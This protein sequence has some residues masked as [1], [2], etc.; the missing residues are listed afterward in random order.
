MGKAAKQTILVVDDEKT[1]RR[2]AVDELKA[3]GYEVLAAGSGAEALALLHGHEG[4]I[5]LLLTDVSMPG[6]SGGELA[7]V[8]GA[9][10][11]GMKILYMSGFGAGA[12]LHDGVREAGVAF[13]AKPFVP[14]TLVKKVRAVLAGA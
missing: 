5:H 11:E 4:E 9:E 7:E 14:A 12:A 1:I 10:R 8:V 3:H 2:L 13:L 6:M